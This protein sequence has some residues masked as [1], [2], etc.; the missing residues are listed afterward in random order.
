MAAAREDARSP[1]TEHSDATEEAAWLLIDDGETRARQLEEPTA[2]E[3]CWA[4]FAS[5]LLR[6]AFK[7][8]LW[9]NLGNHLNVIKR[10]GLGAHA[11]LPLVERPQFR[12]DATAAP[13]M[14][15]VRRL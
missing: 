15:L 6:L 2:R 14:G 10:R 9:S 4:L 7:R 3:V 5:R 12:P 8:R 13:P 11:R 1:A